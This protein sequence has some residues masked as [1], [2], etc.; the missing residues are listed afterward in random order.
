MISNELKNL[1]DR[2]VDAFKERNQHVAVIERTYV[3]YYTN[4]AR[5]DSMFENEE[6]YISVDRTY[7]HNDKDDC[8][9]TI[10]VCK[11]FSKPNN[12]SKRI[13]KVKV[14]KNASDNV[15]NKR[16]TAVIEFMNNYK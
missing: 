5:M 4:R 6:L 7:S 2:T 9:V 1:L 14:P 13:F 15:I 10:E 8:T 3:D 16:V 12:G 11:A